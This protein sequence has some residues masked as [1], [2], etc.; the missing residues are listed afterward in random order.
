[1][2]LCRFIHKANK[3]PWLRK[4]IQEV[5]SLPHWVAGAPAA[6]TV[7]FLKTAPKLVSKKIWK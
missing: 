7:N 5:I 6:A 4:I 1:M 3:E 2:Y